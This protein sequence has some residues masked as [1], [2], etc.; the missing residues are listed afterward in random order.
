[1]LKK[2]ELGWVRKE[3]LSSLSCSTLKLVTFIFVPRHAGVKGNVRA[4]R[5]A[6][7]ASVQDGA[8]MDR[9]IGHS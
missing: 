6:G 8:V 9:Q 3:W 7:E 4:D 2:I 5:L 1:M